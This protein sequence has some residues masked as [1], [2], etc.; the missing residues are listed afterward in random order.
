MEKLTDPN[1]IRKKQEKR[2]ELNHKKEEL[3]YSLIDVTYDKNEYMKV[4][5]DAKSALFNPV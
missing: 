5:N 1:L 2:A 4:Y 3:E